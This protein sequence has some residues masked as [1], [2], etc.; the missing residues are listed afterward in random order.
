MF[1]I[2][3]V[4]L[5][6]IVFC[7]IASFISVRFRFEFARS[8]NKRWR[9]SEDL[10]NNEER[11]MKE[12]GPSARFVLEKRLGFSYSCLSGPFLLFDD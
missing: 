2:E 5:P 6:T 8:V 12:K 3:T 11:T 4:P 9:K 1:N 10:N 7:R